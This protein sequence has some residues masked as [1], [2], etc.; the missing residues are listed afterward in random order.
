MGR[1]SREQ[2]GDYVT[3]AVQAGGFAAL[4]LMGDMNCQ[5]DELVCDSKMDLKVV[6]GQVIVPSYSTHINSR[7]LACAYDMIIVSPLTVQ[8]V[9]EKADEVLSRLTSITSLLL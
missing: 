1:A 8:A 5:S 9:S 4:V 3:H 2:L 7:S 6:G